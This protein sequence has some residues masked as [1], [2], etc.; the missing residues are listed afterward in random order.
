[1][2]KVDDSRE[3]HRMLVRL[4]DTHPLLARLIIGEE[5]GKI[6]NSQGMMRQKVHDKPYTITLYVLPKDYGMFAV[7]RI[8]PRVRFSKSPYDEKGAGS[9]VILENNATVDFAEFKYKDENAE[10]AEPELLRKIF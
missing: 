6:K 9:T 10:P 3:E 4:D 7:N 8:K 5:Y 2:A 1:M